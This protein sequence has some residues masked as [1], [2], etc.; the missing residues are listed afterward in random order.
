[1]VNLTPMPQPVKKI[2]YTASTVRRLHRDEREI[3]RA[4]RRGDYNA[5][6]GVVRSAIGAAEDAGLDGEARRLRTREVVISDSYI[7]EKFAQA[8]EYIEIN[9]RCNYRLQYPGSMPVYSVERIAEE[10]MRDAILQGMEHYVPVFKAYIEESRRLLPPPPK[11]QRVRTPDEI[12]A[13]VRSSVERE[14]NQL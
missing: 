10:A 7:A 5:A 9:D 3:E 6:T 4:V 14:R 11:F 12:E 1:M 13:D 8:R 2:D